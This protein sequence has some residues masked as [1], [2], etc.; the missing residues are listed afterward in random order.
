MIGTDQNSKVKNYYDTEAT[1]YNDIFY[2]RDNEYPPLKY[3]HNYIVQMI[4]EE[5]IP[6]ETHILDAGCGP[7]ELVFDLA[8]DFKSVVGIDISEEM[9]KIAQS[10]KV[11]NISHDREITLRTGD[12]EKTG[13]DDSEF[14]VVIFSGVVEYLNDD[15]KWIAEVSR[16]LKKNGLLIV[17]VTNKYAVRRWTMPLFTAVKSLPGVFFILNFIKT[18]LLGKEKLNRFPFRPRVHSP[19]AFDGLLKSK[20]FE[21]ISHNYFDFSLMP[22]PFDTIFDFLLLKIR[23]NMEKR[24]SSNAWLTGNGYIVKYRQR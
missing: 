3:R 11:V 5:V 22:Y 23:K 1:D 10:K 9:I 21:K 4:K 6:E 7:G 8:K 24:S 13:F 19:S 16:I 12:V 14:G 2:I 18:K 15:E 20:G 17:N